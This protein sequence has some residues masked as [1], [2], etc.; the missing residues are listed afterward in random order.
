MGGGAG[1]TEGPSLGS[2]P[3]PLPAT[4]R[5]R[6]SEPTPARSACGAA[7]CAP[8]S[9][10]SWGLGGGEANVW[11]C[12][13]PRVAERPHEMCDCEAGAEVAGPEGAPSPRGETEQGGG[14]RAGGGCRR[15]GREGPPAPRLCQRGGAGGVDP[16]G[17]G[18]PAPV[19]PGQVQGLVSMVER[20]GAKHRQKPDTT[21]AS[22]CTAGGF[23]EPGPRPSPCVTL[24][25]RNKPSVT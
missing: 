22:D 6:L 10:S 24:S 4:S 18:V 11:P 21:W 23:W 15:G 1:T 13:R 20:V 5:L 16:P 9:A 17:P 19:Q 3:V 2:K 25:G 14:K 12:H 8:A 7:G